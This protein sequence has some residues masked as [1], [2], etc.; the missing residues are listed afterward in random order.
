[1]NTKQ[2]TYKNIGIYLFLLCNF[3][4]HAH[5][6]DFKTES[7][8]GFC[9]FGISGDTD[10]GRLSSDTV[11]MYSQT[12]S[13][14]RELNKHNFIDENKLLLTYEI[15]NAYT[16][17]GYFHS[18]QKITISCVG[19][20]VTEGYSL[21]QPGITS[22]PAQ[23][24]KMLGEEYKVL[25]RGVSGTTLLANGD[26]PY[27]ASQQYKNAINDMPNIVIIMLGSNDSKANNWDS[28]G[29]EF[30]NNYKSLILSFQQLQSRPKIYVA[31]PPMALDN[32]FGINE[33]VLK[34]QIRP[35]IVALANEIGVSLIDIY[36]VSMNSQSDF[37]DGVHPKEGGALK[38][39]KK[40]HD[41]VLVK[42]TIQSNKMVLTAP[43]AYGYQ[44]FKY[45]AK[46]DGATSKSIT[47]SINGNY[48]VLIKISSDIQDLLLTENQSF[49][50]SNSDFLK[51]GEDY[52][53]YPNPAT[54]VFNID[55]GD[56]SILKVDVY[57]LLGVLIYTEKEIESTKHVISVSN[58][59]VGI[60]TLIIFD[61][62]QNTS[63]RIIIQ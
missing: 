51:E 55:G 56:K 14:R 26:S 7:I 40:I 38:I 33:Q 18:E 11:E 28:F 47:P 45:G 49:V 5:D 10:D 23:L 24:R 31:L 62:E 48:T 34:N 3:F 1:M 19:D 9:S 52:K 36:D 41:V 15:F 16:I 20:S 17:K 43:E 61:D 57:N 13:E 60:Y 32:P 42:P 53:I 29:N 46:L 25:N 35:N 21:S 63:K 37:P 58:L 27:T 30:L 12:N 54:T 59:P 50:L 39:A 2:S 44:W 6:E 4:C 22:Y 8:E